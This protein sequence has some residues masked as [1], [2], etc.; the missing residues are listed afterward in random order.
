MPKVINKKRGEVEVTLGEKTLVIV[1]TLLNIAAWEEATGKHW[2]S[3]A[4]KLVST[5]ASPNA[6]EIFNYVGAND[7]IQFFY[8]CSQEE[9]TIGEVG[10]L[11]EEEG[12]V[13][14][15][16]IYVGCMVAAIAP[17]GSKDTSGG[18]EIKKPRRQTTTRTKK[19]V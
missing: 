13:A 14:A 19:K 9:L 8:I 2:L 5:F 16:S 12:L 3:E 10:E 7:L 17:T 11:I 18:G 6:S 1:P 15:A 4:N